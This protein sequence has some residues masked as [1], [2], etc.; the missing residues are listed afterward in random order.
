MNSLFDV[1]KDPGETRNLMALANHA[2]V[3]AQMRARW[4][5]LG[6]EAR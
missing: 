3:L 2:D 5:R 4:E 1:K 6:R